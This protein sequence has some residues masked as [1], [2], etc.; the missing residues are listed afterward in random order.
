MHWKQRFS[1]STTNIAF[2]LRLTKEMVYTLECIYLNQLARG[3]DENF[4]RFIPAVRNLI[5]RGLVEHH[6]IPEDFSS[7]DSLKKLEFHN[8]HKWYVLTPAGTHVVELLKLSGLIKNL[9]V[10]QEAA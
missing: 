4:G 2:N 5:S 9:S 6:D 7:W 10:V 8:N 1:D 3:I